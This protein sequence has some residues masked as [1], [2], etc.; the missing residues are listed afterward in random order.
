MVFMFQR[1]SFLA[2]I[3]ALVNGYTDD[4]DKVAVE[5]E[6]GLHFK[7]GLTAEYEFVDTSTKEFEVSLL[8]RQEQRKQR[9]K[10]ATKRVGWITTIG[11]LVYW[12]GW[13]LIFS[14]VMDGWSYVD[15]MYFVVVSTTTVG[16]GDFN[17]LEVGNG[18]KV[19]FVLQSFSGFILA[20]ILSVEIAL[21]TKRAEAE[22][23]FIVRGDDEET[24]P[25]DDIDTASVALKKTA[26]QVL[27]WWAIGTI[28]YRFAEDGPDGGF[29]D[30]GNP[31]GTA[32]Y[33]TWTS[34][35]TIGFG[36]ICVQTDTAKIFTCF[37]LLLACAQVAGLIGGLCDYKFQQF[38][39]NQMQKLLGMA[40]DGSRMAL[41]D[42]FRDGHVT[43]GELLLGYL[44]TLGKVRSITAKEILA[45]F[46]DLSLGKRFIDLNMFSA[47]GQAIQQGLS[48]G[49]TAAADAKAKGKSAKEQS[50]IAGEA[51][52]KAAANFV[53]PYHLSKLDATEVASMKALPERTYEDLK[54]ASIADID[55]L[56]ASL[57]K[58]LATCRAAK[59]Y[60]V[61]IALSAGNA[62]GAIA[63]ANQ[64]SKNEVGEMAAS[65]AAA[66]YGTTHEMR[67][68]AADAMAEWVKSLGGEE[69][70]FRYQVQAREEA[71]ALV[72]KMAGEMPEMADSKRPPRLPPMSAPTGQLDP[73]LQ[74]KGLAPG[75]SNNTPQ[76]ATKTQVPVQD[77]EGELNK[78]AHGIC[79][80]PP[81]EVPGL[82][83]TR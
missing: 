43:S 8:E 18:I 6:T 35:S 50:S 22:K 13:S 20:G 4:K 24:H 40:H 55:A 83:A 75:G 61:K 79:R 33:F 10:D 64:L 56:E 51:A 71:T 62:A 53:W 7:Q 60:H 73:L 63:R 78:L 1:L 65:A 68:A 70:K 54:D 52:A 26:L 30:Y 74:Q 66:A 27:L 45:K 14:L 25:D 46:R 34:I 28:F 38:E 37:F 58:M 5:H 9:V 80:S 32:W 36:D 49:Q 15:A 11:V 29:G 76:E 41:F 16:Y 72:D 21:A 17:F 67:L 57:E 59:N 44:V 23:D 42:T 77:L 48:A 47:R 81:A 82:A 31:W 3:R 2:P 69:G 12:F 19:L 39:H